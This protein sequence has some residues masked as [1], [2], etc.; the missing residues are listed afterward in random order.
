MKTRLLRSQLGLWTDVYE[1]EHEGI[2]LW[3]SG[4]EVES[5]AR[6]YETRRHQ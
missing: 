4:D 1:V 2:V 3:F 5:A 6:R